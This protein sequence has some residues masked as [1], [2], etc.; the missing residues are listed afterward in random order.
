MGTISKVR[1][2]KKNDPSVSDVHVNKPLTD[3][4]IAY[5]QD[6]EGFVATKMFPNIDV[7]KKSDRYWTYDRGYFWRNQAQ[8]RAPGTESAGITYKVD[9]TPNYFAKVYAVHYDIDDQVEQNADEGI[10]LERDATELVTQQLLIKR[11]TLWMST[12]FVTGVWGTTKTGVTS[13]P[14]A[15]Q[16]IQFDQAASKPIEEI[17]AAMTVIHE[18]TGKRP[19][20]LLMQQKVWDKLQDHPDI[21]GR[22]DSGQTPNG[23]AGRDLRS[24]LAV[25]LGIPAEGILVASAVQNTAVEGATNAVSYIA[26]K[27]LLL[28][29]AEPNPGRLKASAGYTFSWVGRP[30]AGNQGMR[31]K[32]FDMPELESRR[33]EGQMAFD[34]K[35]VAADLGYMFLD[36]VA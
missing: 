2:I 23:P 33:V 4:S 35:L 24:A 16:F 5:L 20:R 19:N 17:R 18:A 36:A 15:S 31:I 3:I 14:S 26:G 29:Y 9:S 13:A 11:E 28:A 34:Q 10:D 1:E 8:E 27:H 25:L 22:L 30:G 12:N 7:Q 6:P 21:V 32:R